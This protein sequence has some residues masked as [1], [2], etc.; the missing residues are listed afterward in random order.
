MM[1]EVIV[2]LVWLLA[3]VI[4]FV[5]ETDLLLRNLD[6]IIKDIKK[7]LEKENK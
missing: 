3:V 1:K 5:V 4:F 2:L 6:K 7:I